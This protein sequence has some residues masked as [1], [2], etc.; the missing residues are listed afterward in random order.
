[1]D[2]ELIMPSSMMTSLFCFD[3]E[4]NQITNIH[5]D[6]ENIKYCNFLKHKKKKQN[7]NTTNSFWQYKKF[8]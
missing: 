8:K 7:N 4:N 1:M 2:K 5:S 3:K 6:I